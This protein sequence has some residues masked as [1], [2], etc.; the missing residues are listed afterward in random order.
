MRTL[1]Y[2]PQRLPSCGSMENEHFKEIFGRS[3]GESPFLL[4][5]VGHPAGSADGTRAGDEEFADAVAFASLDFSRR[6]VH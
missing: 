5:P 3:A 4:I 6:V 1:E 2:A